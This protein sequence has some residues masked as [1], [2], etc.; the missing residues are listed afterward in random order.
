MVL[1]NPGDTFSLDANGNL[2][3]VPGGASGQELAPSAPINTVETLLV[4][5][6]LL[7]GVTLRAGSKIIATLAGTCTSTHGDVPTINLRA[8]ILGTV[9]DALVAAIALPA[10]DGAGAAIP[11]KITVELTI[12]TV[13]PTGTFAGVCT[14]TN[15]GS[16]GLATSPSE[17]VE[18][19]SAV[20]PTTTATFFDVCFVTAAITTTCT[21]TY[22]TITV[23]H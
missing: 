9:A 11:F 21:F 2:I 14:V 4:K 3:A 7:A 20:M 10:S 1:Q 8:G 23:T 12:D 22:A 16:T 17:I 13:G 18:F 15:S 5:A 6:A 19:S